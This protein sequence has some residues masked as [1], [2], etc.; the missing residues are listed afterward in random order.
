MFFVSCVSFHLLLS[1]FW[2]WIGKYF[3]FFFGLESLYTKICIQH[4]KY[5]LT[6]MKSC[7]FF[8]GYQVLYIVYV[9]YIY[10]ADQE[11]IRH[12]VS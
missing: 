8:G 4:C 10:I 3:F 6:L 2:N 1:F 11:Q 7:S 9:I 5:K 12:L